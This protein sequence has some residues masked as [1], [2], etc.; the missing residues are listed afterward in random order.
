MDGVRLDDAVRARGQ[1]TV[2]GLCINILVTPD[3]ALV[4]TASGCGGHRTSQSHALFPICGG[5]RRSRPGARAAS[6]PWPLLVAA[7]RKL[8]T[9]CSSS[10]ARQCRSANS[11]RSACVFSCARCVRGCARVTAGCA[12]CCLVVQAL[13]CQMCCCWCCFRTG[14]LAADGCSRHGRQLPDMGAAGHNIRP[15]S[16]LPSCIRS[17]CSRH[18]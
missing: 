17:A 15:A 18:C 16:P 6:S 2:S 11:G 14:P 5:H 12:L 3:T 13:T 1:Q 7:H 9:A 10:A 4:L 8:A